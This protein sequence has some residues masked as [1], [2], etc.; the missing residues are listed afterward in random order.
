MALPERGDSHGLVG[1][2]W[3]GLLGPTVTQN[4]GEKGGSSA[5]RGK[6]QTGKTGKGHVRTWGQEDVQGGHLGTASPACRTEAAHPCLGCKFGVFSGANKHRGNRKHY[7]AKHLLTL[8]GWES[9][10]TPKLSGHEGNP[11]AGPLS[12]CGAP[13]STHTAWHGPGDVQTHQQ[14]RSKMRRRR[15]GS[16]SIAWRGGAGLSR[17]PQ[18]KGGPAGSGVG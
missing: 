4:K 13:I 10:R 18:A 12:Q 9:G 15:V 16:P 7:P 2:G 8:W 6:V 3:W 14:L 5:S 1:T 17:Q 11:K